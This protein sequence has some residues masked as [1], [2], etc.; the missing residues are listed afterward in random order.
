MSAHSSGLLPPDELADLHIFVVP[1]DLWLEKYRTAF[2]NIAL[3][4]VSAGFVRVQP[5]V[6]LN[7][8][9]DHIEE[10]L[11]PEVVPE[12]Y[13]FLRSVGRCMAVIKENQE[14][15]LKAKDFLPP[16][17][18]SPEIFILP[19]THDSVAKPVENAANTIIQTHGLTTAGMASIQPHQLPPAGYPAGYMQNPQAL[20]NL[21]PG[22]YLP[23]QSGHMEQMGFQTR[24]ERFVNRAERTS[25]SNKSLSD[26]EGSSDYER[27]QG[28]RNDEVAGRRQ[29]LE[30]RSGGSS[31]N[32]GGDRPT[33]M[34]TTEHR[35]K[36]KKGSQDEQEEASNVVPS[37]T[38]KHRMQKK[39]SSSSSGSN[40]SEPKTVKFIQPEVYQSLPVPGQGGALVS[41][42]TPIPSG[43]VISSPFP[44][45]RAE[46]V[47]GPT[48]RDG[49]SELNNN[50]ASGKA[51]EK[52][53]MAS[54]KKKKA[55][56]PKGGKKKRRD[57]SRSPS[58]ERA[59]HKEHSSQKENSADIIYEDQNDSAVYGE[60]TVSRVESPPSLSEVEERSKFVQ[61]PSPAKGARRPPVPDEMQY[62]NAFGNGSHDMDNSFGR[63]DNLNNHVLENQGLAAED[64]SANDSTGVNDFSL[65]EDK[66]ALRDTSKG[67]EGERDVNAGGKNANKMGVKDAAKKEG[68][69][70]NA[71]KGKKTAKKPVKKPVET[72]DEKY[73][74]PP[75]PKVPT[76]PPMKYPQRGNK[77]LGEDTP[78]A[79]DRKRRELEELKA[80]LRKAK[81]ARVDTEKER[82]SKVR[83]AKMLQ[84]QILQKKNQ[85][86]NIWKK[87]FFEEK[88]KTAALEEQ[89]NRLRHEVDAQHKALMS[90]LE[91]KE[92]E[93]GKPQGGADFKSP[94]EKTNQRMSL[95]R[96]QHEV[97]ELRRRIEELKMK[98]TAEM[99]NR[100][101]AQKELKQIRQDLMEKKINLTL[102]KSQKSLA[103]LANP[104][105]IAV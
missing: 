10:Q 2:N 51:D 100:D 102:T 31:E 82:E 50:D 76:P 74:I 77:D 46:P 78:S 58:V 83:R 88:R 4:S 101:A 87:K 53:V 70:G 90:Y 103:T 26:D 13:V 54:D 97:E 28:E 65:D 33:A 6:S 15:L 7:Y 12:D 5:Y 52:V 60:V 81:N 9:R 37:K 89:V 95:A 66:N 64:D 19:G 38:K 62:G 21:L 34:E 105:N 16:V 23:Q 41:P 71:A 35:K 3:E 25:R 72:L 73:K 27:P 80:E 75:I 18:Y 61:F 47:S 56:D 79:K 92:R 48:G 17:A 49:A 84:N 104:E 85:S 42:P 44:A 45:Q 93:G 68:A 11:G 55:A 20:S 36:Q 96:L 24:D 22:G 94:S 40:Q 99:K 57:R 29:S 59:Q 98:L 67:V 8:L 43:R 91:N 14:R 63:E 86:K 32:D 1:L 30:D 39:G 69:K